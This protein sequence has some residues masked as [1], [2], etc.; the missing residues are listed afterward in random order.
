MMQFFKGVNSSKLKYQQNVMRLNEY[1]KHKQL[2]HHIQRRLNTYYD[3]KYT[4]HYFR[5]AEILSHFS[6]QMRQEVRMFSCRKLVEN[7]YFFHDLPMS[8]LVRIV[9]LLKSD[10]LLTNDVIVKANQIGDCMYF[11]ASGTV[12]VYTASGKEVCHLDSG[13]HFGE[14]ALVMPDAR[15]VATVVAV[16]VCKLYRL[17]RA[18]FIRTIHPYPLLWDRIKK[19]AYERVERT[20]MLNV[21]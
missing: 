21:Q 3:F 18:D 7:V 1:M 13:A 2:P 14:I 12:A 20:A 4:K 10:I 5:E 17:E 16:E 15:R 8:M 6:D 11:I 9:T 19:I